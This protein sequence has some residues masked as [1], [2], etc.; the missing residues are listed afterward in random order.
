MTSIPEQKLS[1]SLRLVLADLRNG[2]SV[3]DSEQFREVLT[4]LQYFIPVILGEIHREWKFWGLD[5]VLPTK[6]RR[7][8]EGEI[9][10]FGLCCFVSDQTLTPVHLYLQVSTSTDEVSWLECKLG[11]SGENGMLR[12]PWPSSS[13]MSKLLYTLKGREETIEWVYKVT[14]GDR[15]PTFGI[16]KGKLNILAEDNEHLADFRDYMP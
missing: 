5:D 10:I 13:A 6:A 3:P 8:G 2:A 4:S 12:T 7:T 16:C 9:E 14:C 1:R 11:E 15:R